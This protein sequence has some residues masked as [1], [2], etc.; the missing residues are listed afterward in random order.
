MLP[1][2]LPKK[3][4]LAIPGIFI[5]LAL[6]LTFAPVYA[7]D[8]QDGLDAYDR[9]DYKTALEKFKPLAE[10]GNANAQYS[11]GVMFGNGNGVPQNNVQAHMWF[12]IAGGDEEKMVGMVGGM[13]RSNVEKQMTPDQIAEA[14]RLAREWMENH[15]N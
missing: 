5:F 2:Y 15:G 9:G 13:A 4:N 12:N 14:Q 1:S 11:L 10:Q 6:A 8:F 3:L 7:D